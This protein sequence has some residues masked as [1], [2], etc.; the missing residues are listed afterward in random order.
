MKR[1]L[2]YVILALLTALAVLPF[3]AALAAPAQ[4]EAQPVIVQPAQDEAVRGVVQIVGTATHPQFLRYELY[5]APWPV[6]SDQSWVFIGDTHSNQ[7]PLGL[8]GTWDSRSVPDGAYALRVRV[9]K[10]DGNYFDSD[11]RRVLVANTRPVASPTPQVTNTPE[12]IPTAALPTATVVIAI[13][14]PEVSPTFEPTPTLEPE[15]TPILPAE[16][17]TGASQP[18]ATTG[19]L[20]DQLFGSNRLLDIAKKAALYTTGAFAAI[21]VFFGIKALL[22][23]LWHKVR[24]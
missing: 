13:P 15:I 19:G 4:Q 12:P 6:P 10:V 14:V 18:G 21:G 23:W 5:Y 20:T 7:Q 9:V 24:P 11:P 8:L 22:V 16:S 1:L 17:A 2:F 3:A